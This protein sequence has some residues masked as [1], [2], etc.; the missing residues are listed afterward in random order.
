MKKKKIQLIISLISSVT[1]MLAVALGYSLT[2]HIDR[3]KVY[4][5]VDT[6]IDA[7]ETYNMTDEEIKDLPT[8]KIEEQTEEQE[9]ATGEEQ[10]V[11]ETEGF[12][13]QGDIA[14]N[15][16]NEFPN[17]SLG[18]Y[19]GLT[20]YSQ[21]DSRWSSHPYTVVGNPSQT[22]G[23]SG[24]RANICSNGSNSYKRGNYARCNGRFI[25]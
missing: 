16:D 2:G 9:K 1:I 14:Y 18:N 20:Y 13:L 11:T 10:Q 5:A 23:S 12:L 3:E 22:I 7:I 8:T 15:G 25:C 17:V 19:A 6:V 21:I 24:C 4:Q